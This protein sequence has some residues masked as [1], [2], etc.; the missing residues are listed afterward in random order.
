[1]SVS[2][3][4]LVNVIFTESVLVRLKAEI[5][6]VSKMAPKQRREAMAARFAKM[7]AAYELA[8]RGLF[9]STTTEAQIAHTAEREMRDNEIFCCTV[10]L[11]TCY[12]DEVREWWSSDEL[13]RNGRPVVP[14]HAVGQGG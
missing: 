10:E 4:P 11:L 13:R 8:A 12:A 14:V 9:D 5:R 6:R 1:M 3:T 2:K 7:L